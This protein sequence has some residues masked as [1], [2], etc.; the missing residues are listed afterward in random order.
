MAL[1][2]VSVLMNDISNTFLFSGLLRLLIHHRI[3]NTLHQ[4][5]YPSHFEMPAHPPRA[6]GDYDD[7]RRED[8]EKLLGVGHA[9][10]L[11]WR[12]HLMHRSGLI[13]KLLLK[14]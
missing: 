5:S 8:Y 1:R 9:L 7:V 2:F 10:I 4:S 13:T 3:H 11:R 12:A 6:H 14:L